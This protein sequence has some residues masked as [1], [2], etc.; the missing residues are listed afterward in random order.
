VVATW[1]RLST[2]GND[3][4][5]PFIFI[6]AALGKNLH[7]KKWT[8][9]ELSQLFR[10]F[11][12][13]FDGHSAEFEIPHLFDNLAELTSQRWIAGPRGLAPHNVVTDQCLEALRA[14]LPPGDVA[15]QLFWFQQLSF[16]QSHINGSWGLDAMTVELD[17]LVEHV[18][19]LSVEAAVELIRLVSE[20]ELDFHD[21]TLD[22]L[23]SDRLAEELFMEAQ[24]GTQAVIAAWA[25]T[26]NFP[27]GV[28]TQVRAKFVQLLSR[29]PELHKRGVAASALAGW[30]LWCESLEHVQEICNA[31]HVE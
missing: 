6:G 21:G 25:S 26:N 8:V 14:V 13:W 11:I 15:N 1:L 18:K 2:G 3:E 5:S 4:E 16:T 27:S 22:L 31:L 10:L 20:E 28:S 17:G 7:R 19:S 30:M 23:Q 12:E 29:L 9:P 24:R